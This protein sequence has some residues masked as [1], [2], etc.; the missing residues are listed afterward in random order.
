MDFTTS[1]TFDDN[2][3]IEQSLTIPSSMKAGR[4]GSIIAE[5]DTELNYIAI[6]LDVA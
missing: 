6:D 4:S 5:S 3:V 1:Y 2:K